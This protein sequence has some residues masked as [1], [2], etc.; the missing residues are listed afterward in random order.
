[1]VFPELT[2]RLPAW[3]EGMAAGA[4]APMPD[5]ADRMGFVIELARRNVASG[6]GPFGAA[7]FDGGGCL[8]APGVNLVL[9]ARCS[10]LH[11]EIVALML[12]QAVLGRHDL[13]DNGRGFHEL[14]TSTEP[15]AM[16]FGAVPWSGI[17]RL[18]CGAR[19][20][21]A[22]AVG[23]D[24]GAKVPSWIAALRARGIEVVRDVQRREAAA[25]LRL[26]VAS[27]GRVYNAGTAI[28]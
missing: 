28:P 1:M 17:R 13:S 6:G 22:R 9:P 2:V 26:Y 3:V 14:C 18:V 8:V 4:S 15:C 10:V 5:I 21:D 24:E 27:G 20:A 23:F 7:V 25:V 12:A 16:C 19:A 11:A